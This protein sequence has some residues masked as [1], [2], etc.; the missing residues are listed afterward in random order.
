MVLCLGTLLFGLLPRSGG[1]P[2]APAEDEEEEDGGVGV[3]K[4][5][6]GG[7]S[8]FFTQR[9]RFLSL[10]L[11]NTTEHILQMPRRDSDFLGDEA[12]EP[13]FL[14]GLPRPLVPALFDGGSAGRTAGD[15]ASSID[16]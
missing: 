15:L 16:E 11:L 3:K 4:E 12:R 1:A 5:R 10:L 2:S 14:A 7:M 8:V 9:W 13:L 6:F